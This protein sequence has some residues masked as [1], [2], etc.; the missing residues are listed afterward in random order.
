[1]ENFFETICAVATPLSAGSIGVIR[2]SGEKSFEII[3]KIF[4]RHIKVGMINHGWIL[5][6]ESGE[7]LDEVIVLPFK[8]P[9]SFTG[10]D[11]VEI[12][13]HGSPVI[14]REILNLVMKNGAKLAQRGEF[15][16]RAFL[17]HKIDLS[18]AEA[19]LDLINAKTSKSAS[20]AANNLSG[21]LKKEIDNIRE[22]IIEILA[23]ITASLDFPE[24][25]AEVEYSEI[26]SVLE[27]A[28]SKINKILQNA[29][30]HNV[31]REGIQ[32]AIAGKPNVGKSS[33]FNALLNINR[34]I[35]TDIAGTTRDTISESL[36]IKG[37]SATLIDTAGI[38]EGKEVDTVER[39]GV[40]NS[41]NTIDN[42]DIILCLYDGEK[43]LEKEDTEVFQLAGTS[44]N[45]LYVETKQ[46]KT[47]KT[48]PQGNSN[49]GQT[50]EN[51]IIIS[52]TT[53][54]GIENLKNAIFNAIL[55][56]NIEDSGFLT[57]Q[58]HQEALQKALSHIENAI[59]AANIEE[60][61]DL[62]SIDI[63][64]ALLSLGEISG[65]VVTDEVLNRIFDSFCI[66]K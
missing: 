6:D 50:L 43:G 15:T 19:V 20:L 36:D 18:Q 56:S 46:D 12:Q 42:S 14:I 22:N 25:V 61:Q 44:K 9:K 24:D 49:V 39:I 27:K 45:R 52:S 59:N 13:T 63:K 35:V 48:A 5:A 7:K 33:L 3:S 8:N 34:A 53:L 16:K 38:R 64:S 32:I 17:N 41:K 28:Q 47:G 55:G 2:I 40:E 37:I 65:E 23:K 60:L 30:C 62:I 31:L 4:D 58:R 66:G 1:M 57:N 10:E 54:F 26:L 21:T 51:P 29:R 11:V